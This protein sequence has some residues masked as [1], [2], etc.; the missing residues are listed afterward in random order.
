MYTDKSKIFI[1]GCS[2]SGTTLMLRLFRAFKDTY[3]YPKEAHYTKFAELDAPESF[4]VIKRNAKTRFDL[5]KI[6]SDIRI[7]HLVRH[8]YDVLTSFH[9]G[10]KRPD[11]FYLKPEQWLEHFDVFKRTI[12]R[13]TPPAH[14]VLRYEDVISDPD[15]C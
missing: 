2:R 5:D 8:P 9:P 13:A 7:V 15:T 3:T 10:S 14:I 11:K 4:H 6:D 1:N 12:N